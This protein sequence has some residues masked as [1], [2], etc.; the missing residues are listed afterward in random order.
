MQEIQGDQICISFHYRY[1][2]SFSY[3]NECNW[4]LIKYF[5][6]IYFIQ[7]GEIILLFAVVFNSQTVFNNN[8][9]F[10]H[11]FYERA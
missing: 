6:Y 7:S 9:A 3:L 1:K 10:D 8:N 11:I 4:T 5:Y 2:F